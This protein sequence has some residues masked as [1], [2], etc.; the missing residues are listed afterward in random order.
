MDDT[1]THGH[2]E[3]VLRSH[4]WRTAQNSASYLLPFLAP[5]MSLLDVGCGPGTITLDLA[6]RVAHGYTVGID[7]EADVVADAQRL[8]DS[9][10]ISGVEFRTGT[11]TRSGSVTSHST[12]STPTSCSSI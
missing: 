12:S 10:P 9:R 5:G 1:Y 2:H 7:R 8:L 3:S 11:H 4:R 6:A